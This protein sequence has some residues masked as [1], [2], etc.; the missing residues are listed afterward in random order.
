MPVVHVV[1]IAWK[2][3]AT[4]ERR[5]QARTQ[6]QAFGE[7]IPGI[8]TVVEGPSV[9]PEGL[10]R[11]HDYA[12]VITFADE[13]ARDAYLPHPVHREFVA[14]LDGWTTEVTVYDLRAPAAPVD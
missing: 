5:Q 13:A 4:S 8:L 7:R 11:G 12:L 1:L 2:P 6:A 3:D 10:E 9:S 14:L